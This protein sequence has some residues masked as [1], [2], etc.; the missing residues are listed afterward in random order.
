MD[1]DT[2]YI[3]FL[4]PRKHL[5]NADSIDNHTVMGQWYEAKP[6]HIRLAHTDVLCPRYC[7]DSILQVSQLFPPQ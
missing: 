5:Y 1:N 4:R 2:N 7:R 3:F 6:I